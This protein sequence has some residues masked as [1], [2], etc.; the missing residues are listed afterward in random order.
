MLIHGSNQRTQHL[1]KEDGRA[2]HLN[3]RIYLQLGKLDPVRGSS[4]IERIWSA[5][6]K[7]K[8]IGEAD[9]SGK[10]GDYGS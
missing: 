3:V 9:A 1:V 2:R 7:G 8:R 10:F 6:E 5:G 4:A